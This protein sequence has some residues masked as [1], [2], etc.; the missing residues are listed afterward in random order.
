MALEIIE[1]ARAERKAS[2]YIFPGRMPDKPVAKYSL[3]QA[4]RRGSKDIAISDFRPHDLR[5]TAA[6]SMASAGIPRFVVARVLNH[7]DSGVTA[8]YDRYSYDREKS[9][10]LRTWDSLLAATIAGP[11]NRR[12]TRSTPFV[13]A[14]AP[15]AGRNA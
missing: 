1:Q 4:T 15:N 10:A 14:L 5:R 12:A 6:S 2:D 11:T 13:T 3:S 8:V 7:V 9:E